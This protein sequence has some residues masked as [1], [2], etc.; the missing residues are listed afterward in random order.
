MDRQEMCERLER[1]QAEIGLVEVNL[2][3]NRHQCSACGLTIREDF[4][5]HQLREQLKGM[6]D[7]LTRAIGSLRTKQAPAS[8]PKAM[9]QVTED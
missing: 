7:K 5:E 8:V 1:A 6:R 2:N 4:G 9:H 3:D